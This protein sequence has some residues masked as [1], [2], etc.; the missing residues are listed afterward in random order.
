MCHLDKLRISSKGTRK[1]LKQLRS[2]HR[3]GKF[4]GDS[5][6]E[7]ECVNCNK[8]VALNVDALLLKILLKEHKPNHAA[9]L[10]NQ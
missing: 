7:V 3:N 1:V 9:R 6:I 10:S 5:L 4:F 2:F 8:C